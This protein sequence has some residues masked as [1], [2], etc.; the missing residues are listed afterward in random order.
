MTTTKWTRGSPLPSKYWVENPN[1]GNATK[2]WQEL[3]YKVSG[4]D[5]STGHNRWYHIPAKGYTAL[6]HTP[7]NGEP[8]ISWEDWRDTLNGVVQQGYTEG[9]WVYVVADH[10]SANISKGSIAKFEKGY[11]DDSCNLRTHPGDRQVSSMLNCIRPATEKEIA[12][13]QGTP[14]PT[15]SKEWVPKVGEWVVP[16]TIEG[17]HNRE[18]GK[19]YKIWETAPNS[20]WVRMETAQHTQ[21]GG[22]GGIKPRNCR[23]ATPEEIRKAEGK[24]DKQY[25]C[26]SEDGVKLYDKDE[27]FWVYNG[28]KGW[29]WKDKIA[30]SSLHVMSTGS[31]T[32][33][34]KDGEPMWKVFSTESAAKAWIEQQNNQQ[35]PVTKGN[36]R[37]GMKVVR[38]KDWSWGDSGQLPEG[39]VGEITAI[40]NLSTKEDR[41]TV[42]WDTGKNGYSIDG[43]YDL[44]IAPGESSTSKSIINSQTKTNQKQTSY[45]KS[46]N[47]NTGTAVNVSA[48]SSTV[49][50]ADRRAATPVRQSGQ[51]LLTVRGHRSNSQGL[52]LS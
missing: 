52:R 20:A 39:V 2:E 41:V 16:L 7:T 11:H 8:C 17:G 13:A 30:L 38:G 40:Y 10:S 42:K 28:N 34:V 51:S 29:V 4:G 6:M 5:T 50:R 24:P 15:E 36:A 47:N 49:C 44:Y 46:S 3:W 23:P 48:N 45:E 33:T 1:P 14:L 18:V 12:Q 21:Y 27:P 35:I 19:A 31:L 43:K 22:D 37:V 32:Q 26:T 25:I 9:Q